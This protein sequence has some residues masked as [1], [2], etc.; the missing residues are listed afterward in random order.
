MAGSV[1]K[2]ILVGNLGKDPEVRRMQSGDAF[3]AIG[4]A[5]HAGHAHA[6]ETERRN[7]WACAAES[8]LPHESILR[9]GARSP[10]D[11][12]DPV[13]IRRVAKAAARQQSIARDHSATLPAEPRIEPLGVAARRVEHQ[14]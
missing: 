12:Q 8:Q 6:A 5:I 7:H 14:Q 10:V 2:V 1:N 11:I 9:R 3:F 4:R 13:E